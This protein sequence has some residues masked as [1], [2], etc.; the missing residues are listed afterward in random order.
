MGTMLYGHG[1]PYERCFDEL[2]L[3]APDLVRSIHLDY[4]QAGAEIIETNSFGANVVKLAEHKLESKVREINHAAV[5]IARQARD[6]AGRTVFIAGSV[7]PLGRSLAPVGNISPA[8]AQAYFRQQIEA[9]AEA[10]VDLIML[11]TIYDLSEMCAAVQAART[12]C[13]LPVVAQMTF[14]EDGTTLV[15]NKPAEIIS[16]LEELRVDVI[17]ANCSVGPQPML[18]VI[19]QMLAL[20]HTPI[21]AQPNAGFPAFAQGRYVYTSSPD[22]MAERARRMVEM[23]VRIVGGC[24]GT[25]PEHIAA[26]RQA[27]A[28]VT[29][30]EP[31]RISVSIARHERQPPP[32]PAKEVTPL[33]QKLGRKFVVTVE[34]DPPKGFDATEILRGATLLREAGVDAIDVADSPRAQA[35]MSAL[36]LSALIQRHAGIEVI[37]HVATRHRNLIALHSE[38]TGAHALGVRNVFVVMGDLPHIGDYPAATAVADI[39]PSGLIELLHNFNQGIGISGQPLDEPTAFL[40]GCAVNFGA[41]NLDRELRVFEKK[42]AAGA[43]FA[44]TQPVYD[45][46]T[47]ERSLARLGGQFPIPIILGVLPLRSQRHAEFLH[48]EVPGIVIPDD[49]MARM[50][51]PAKKPTEEGVR[52]AQELLLAVQDKVAGAYFMPPFGKYEIVPQV[53]EGLKPLKVGKLDASPRSG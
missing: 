44:L 43:Q 16:S 13:D 25:T 7:G 23:G 19:E 8:Q 1:I 3:S 5:Q 21:S 18:H 40:V 45:P 14:T 34:V 47:V 30:I 51:D 35:R 11:E 2:N 48:N 33:A 27:L 36:A 4:V 49:V 53:L 52:L 29:P 15:G 26:I 46:A 39:T 9:L 17:G 38:L 10:G 50:R 31:Q 22:Y 24:C 28:G 42:V 12:V 41:E 20:S 37:L 6:T 32:P